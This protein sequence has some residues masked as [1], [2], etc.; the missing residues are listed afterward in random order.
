MC[1]LMK[2]QR[3]HFAERKTG[4][5]G[6]EQ[7]KCVHN[8][9]KTLGQTSRR[10]RVFIYF[11]FSVLRSGSCSFVCMFIFNMAQNKVKVW[12]SIT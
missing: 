9:P 5:T 2:E 3:M 6:L 4:L 1:I 10:D 12:A 11:L 8:P 7:I